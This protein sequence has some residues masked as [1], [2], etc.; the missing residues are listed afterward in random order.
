MKKQ[1]FTILDGTA[2]LFAACSKSNDV[3]VVPTQPATGDYIQDGDTLNSLNGSNGR[4]IK[5][6]LKQGGTYYL[7]SGAGDAVINTG[8]TL[9]VQSGCSSN[10]F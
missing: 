4:S 10:L 2:I 6:T 9:I 1:L 3:T 5:G 7:Y 8:D